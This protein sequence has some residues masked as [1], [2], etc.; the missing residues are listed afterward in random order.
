[1]PSLRT[2]VAATDFSDFSERVVQRAAQIA[3]QH[4]STMHLLHVVRP[5]ELYPSLT[6]TQDEFSRHD[7]DFQEAERT[8]LQAIASGVADTFGIAVETAT[9]LGRAHTEIGAYADAVSA[10]LVV[11]GARGENT[12]MD[13]FLGSTA[14]RLMRGIHHPV[15]IVRRPAT[16]AYARVLAAVDFSPLS[17]DVVTYALSLASGAEVE[18]LHVQGSEVEHR[19]RRAR[20]EQVDIADWLARLRG[21]AERQLDALLAPLEH[22]ASVARRVVAGFP[23]AALC[24]YID[25]HRVDLVVLGRHGESAG[26]HD[27]LLGSVSRDVALATTA[28]VLMIGP[29]GKAGG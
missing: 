22:G 15:L 28:D 16:D 18:A 7:E 29:G 8:R 11:I 24:Q 2:I 17:A 5:L 23:P 4:G 25:D 9:R 19:L 21:E 10:D 14:A 27:W 26:L 12:L 20:Y 1:M 3:K 6:L 13:L